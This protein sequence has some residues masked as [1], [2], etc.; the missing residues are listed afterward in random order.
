MLVGHG[1]LAPPVDSLGLAN[2]HKRQR[3]CNAQIEKKKVNGP[4]KKTTT[5]KQHFEDKCVQLL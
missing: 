1:A 2:F 3:N 4:R 5:Q